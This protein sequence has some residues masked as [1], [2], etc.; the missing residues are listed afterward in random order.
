VIVNWSKSKDD[1][2]KA[3]MRYSIEQWYR[4]WY[5]GTDEAMRVHL[6]EFDNTYDPARFDTDDIDKFEAEK[7]KYLTELQERV[8]EILGG[9]GG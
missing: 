7:Q 4:S 2:T 3:R 9:T 5:M 6:S 8:D 1:I